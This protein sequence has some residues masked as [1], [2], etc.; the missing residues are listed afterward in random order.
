MVLANV[1]NRPV[2]GASVGLPFP[3]HRERLA[4]HVVSSLRVSWCGC[5]SIAGGPNA[6]LATNRPHPIV[7]AGSSA[8]AME[9][10][11]GVHPGFRPVCG[12]LEMLE[13]A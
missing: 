6:G 7:P 5:R 2:P 10:P 3:G 12:P 13:R 4:A 8:L 11:W 9:A 1:K